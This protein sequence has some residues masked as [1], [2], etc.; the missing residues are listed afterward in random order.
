MT[1]TRSASLA[2]IKTA[3]IGEAFSLAQ[4]ESLDLTVTPP[5]RHWAQTNGSSWQR[6]RSSKIKRLRL[7]RAN[8]D[9][10]KAD[11]RM[12]GDI[13]KRAASALPPVSLAC[14]RRLPN[15]PSTSLST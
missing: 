14:R 11:E 8:L 5:E 13:V 1:S 3:A 7:N 9:R 4:A 2:N 6:R 12:A 10:M 15:A